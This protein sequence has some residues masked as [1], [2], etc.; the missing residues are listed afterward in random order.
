MFNDL[1]GNDR[2]KDTLRKLS[3]N[4]RVPNALLLA[5]PDGV[6]KREFA[7]R[8]AAGFLCENPTGADPCGECPACVHAAV[9]NIPEPEK[10]DDFKQVFSSEHPDLGMVV[11]FNRNILVDAIRDLE[12]EANFRPYVGKARFFIID[13]A[14][15]MNDAASNALL[16]TLEE[17]AP[18][19]H[20]ILVTSRSDSLLQTIRSRCQTIRFAP[21]D[22]N[23]IE[24]YLTATGRFSH[25][26]ARLIAKLSGGSVGRALSLEADELRSRR[27]RMLEVLEEIL[28][29]LNRASL[30]AVSEAIA[31]AKNKDKFE[32]DLAILESLIHDVWTLK[33]TGDADRLANSELAN[34]LSRLAQN[35]QV[36]E[37][38]QWLDEI[39]LIRGR[40][41]VNINKRIAVDA[42]FMEMAA[43]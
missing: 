20:I 22:E 26:D 38:T 37:L 15:K 11:P 6:G 32:L 25:D 23:A 21:V 29:K 35:S 41:K 17:P 27:S 14:D 36:G 39:E 33:I 19:S 7:V 42:L 28:V 18:T 9:F 16:K 40:T 24:E 8:L 1:I 12:R 10:K 4:G 31:D 30:L 3:E 5:G 13:D 34:H 43:R 2:A